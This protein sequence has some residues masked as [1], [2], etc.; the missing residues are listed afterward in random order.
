[1]RVD[2]ESEEQALFV[3]LG[4][5]ARVRVMEPEELRQRVAAETKAMSDAANSLAVQR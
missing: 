4:M 3:A 5:G 1:M 2:F